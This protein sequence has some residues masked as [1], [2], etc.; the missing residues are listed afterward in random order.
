MNGWKRTGSRCDMLRRLLTK[1]FTKVQLLLVSFDYQFFKKNGKSGSCTMNAHPVLA[2]DEELR[3]K[4]NEI[5]DYI[6]DNYNMED[7]I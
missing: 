5:V 4:V 7:I 6:R 2:K 3:T 1:N